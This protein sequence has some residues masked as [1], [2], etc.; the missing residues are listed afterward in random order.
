MTKFELFHLI[1]DRDCAE[2][3]KYL[4]DHQ[5]TEPFS[6]RNVHY[7]CHAK[8]LIDLSGATEVPAVYLLEEKKL[9]KGKNEILLWLRSKPS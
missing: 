3:R 8:A 4:V 1:A 2:V 7:E 6:F 9:I 5:M